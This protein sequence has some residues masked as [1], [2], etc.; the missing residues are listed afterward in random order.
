MNDYDL[1]KEMQN[2]LMQDSK[3]FF[4]LLG[5]LHGSEVLNIFFNEQKKE[6]TIQIDDLYANFLEL[7]EYKDLKNVSFTI[8][9]KSYNICLDK[10]DDD[11]ISIY[12]VEISNNYLKI[13]FLP[14]GY[15]EVYFFDIH[16]QKI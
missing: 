1:L 6:C 7:P 16:L 4:E 8:S 12:D 5:G 14:S 9:T 13:L 15:L 11:V 2:M 3:S 10:Q